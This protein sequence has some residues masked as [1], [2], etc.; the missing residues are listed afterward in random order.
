MSDGTEWCVSCV[1]DITFYVFN[2]GDKHVRK[3]T[4][5]LFDF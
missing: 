3:V 2:V 4:D 1:V 5:Y